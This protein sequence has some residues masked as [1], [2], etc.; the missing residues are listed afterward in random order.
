MADVISFGFLAV[1][2]WRWRCGRRAVG[3]W[4]VRC[5]SVRVWGVSINGGGGPF[6]SAAII[7]VMICQV[8][9]RDEEMANRF[10][11]LPSR[12]HLLIIL[13]RRDES[14]PSPPP[15][16]PPPPTT[17][18]TQVANSTAHH[19]PLA[20]KS[21]FGYI[22]MRSH[23]YNYIPERSTSPALEFVVVP[24]FSAATSSTALPPRCRYC[25]SLIYNLH[26]SDSRRPCY[27]EIPPPR[28]RSM[29]RY[30]LYYYYYAFSVNYDHTSQH[31]KSYYYN[32]IVLLCIYI[33]S[34][35]GP[36]PSQPP[37]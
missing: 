20:G 34:L 33:T 28:P 8:F 9:A 32:V 4:S 24:G 31:S 30:E 16:P 10:V 27:P 13:A 12:V 29:F 35:R 22:Y 6:C 2:R 18:T 21:N 7:P 25:L 11:E 1:V 36:S 19:S 3:G 15:P 23:T 14:D 37:S 5:Y 17:T 26:C